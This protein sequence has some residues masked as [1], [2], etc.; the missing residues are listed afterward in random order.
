[1]YSLKEKYI[2]DI[3]AEYEKVRI[4]HKNKKGQGPMLSI[5]EARGNSFKTDWKN[6]SSLGPGFI[7]VRS[8]KNYPLEKIVP[9]IDWTPF[10]QA[11]ELAGRYPAILQDSVVGETASG[12][13]RD[14]QVM[15]KKIVDQNGCLPMLCTGYSLPILSIMMILKYIQMKQRPKLQ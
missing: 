12:L 6:Y 9:Y 4:Q 15:L 14:A 11:W 10:F 2:D 5:Q 8:L 1:M 7:G 13:F 3:K